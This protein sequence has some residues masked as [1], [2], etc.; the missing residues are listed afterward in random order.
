[1]QCCKPT[2]SGKPCK[3]LVGPGQTMCNSHRRQ[4]GVEVRNASQGQACGSCLFFRGHDCRRYPPLDQ[5][6]EGEIK[7]YWPNTSKDE[8]CGEYRNKGAK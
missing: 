3:A 7:S 5:V 6:R 1:M 8:W 2:Q 4:E